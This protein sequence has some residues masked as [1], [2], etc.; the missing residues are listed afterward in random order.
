MAAVAAA[1]AGGGPGADRRRQHSSP[2]RSG[3]KLDRINPLT[4]VKNLFSLR[5]A[6]RLGKSLIPAALLA[7]FAVQRIARQLQIPP[8]S[9]ARLEL[10]GADVFGLLQAAAWLLFGWAAIDFLVEWQSRDRA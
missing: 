10:L 1:G 4:N 6:A 3:F 2:E 8:F 9:T 5:A 7:V